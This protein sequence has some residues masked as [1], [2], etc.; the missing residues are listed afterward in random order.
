MT[1]LKLIR[2]IP[3]TSVQVGAG[4]M[5]YTPG[6]YIIAKNL[7]KLESLLTPLGISQQVP[8]KMMDAITA[9]TAC[10]SAYVYTVIKSM[11]DGLIT[12]GIPSQNAFK[13]TSQ[14]VVGA[15]KMVL[16]TGR[17]PA[18]LRDE[19]CLPGESTIFGIHE[20]EKFGIRNGFINAIETA[21]KKN[22]ELGKLRK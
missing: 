10:G 17:H 2:M 4:C 7:E 18:I 12:L 6:R 21:T 9:L 11:A 16:E 14:T 1:T 22:E 19:L 5:V 13:L 8:E 3:N 20:L 15:A